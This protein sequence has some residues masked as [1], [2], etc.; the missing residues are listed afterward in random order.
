MAFK[1]VLAKNKQGYKW[2][3]VK[4]GPLD[5]ATGKRKQVR[6]RADTKR[7]AE[8]NVDTAIALLSKGIHEKQA[9][10]ITFE[11][12][13]WEWYETY[14]KSGVKRNTL[15]LRRHFLRFLNNYYGKMP[16][17]RITHNVH[18]KALNKM[19]DEGYSRSTIE[20][21]HA[22]ANMVF[23]YGIRNKVLLDNPALGSMMPKR[24]VTVEDIENSSVEDEYL[25]RDELHQIIDAAK[26]HGLEGDFEMIFLEMFSGM[27]PGE[28]FALKYQDLIVE[29]NRISITKTIYHEKLNMFRYELTPP[30]TPAGIRS[31]TIDEI[32]VQMLDVY[33]KKWKAI[34]KAHRPEHEAQFIFRRK[35]GWPYNSYHLRSRFQRLM[36]Y[37]AITKTFTPYI[38]RH[39]Y[40][41]MLAEAG[42][43]LQ[44]IMQRI[45]HE[46]SKTTLRVYTH[47]T[48]IMQK[49]A[50][51][52]IRVAFKDILEKPFEKPILQDS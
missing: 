41:S 11:E 4:D 1:K 35:S 50:D 13:G 28:M 38:F 14:S 2:E 25:N 51:E 21:T 12:V 29:E 5:A 22:T 36:K 6:R 43:D 19:D 27:R 39:T 33:I 10:R 15:R 3:C 34:D 30:K 47:V 8:A 42:V 45:G 48:K 31:F 9:D 23:K 24:T 52:K 20:Q 32:V 17:S 46:D 37:T 44:T 18:Q 26:N 16:I 40:V 49:N 7:E